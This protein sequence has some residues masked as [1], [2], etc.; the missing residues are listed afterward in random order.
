[1]ARMQRAGII[2][3][4]IGCVIALADIRIAQGRLR[5]AMRSYGRGL[6]LAMAQGHPILRGIADMYVGMSQL[7]CEQN[8]L[9]S[10]TEHLL[11]SQELGEHMG[12]PQNPYRWRVAMARITQAQGDLDGALELLEEAQRRYVGDFFPNVRPVAALVT[13]LWL[14]QGRLVEALDWAHE[15]GLSAHDELSYLHE[16]EHITLARILLAHAQTDRSGHALGEAT[17]LLAR[18][19]A[20]AEAGER[21]GNVIEILILQA[22]AHQVQSDIP[23]ALAPL[24]RALTLAEREG[25]VR[26]F[27]DEGPLMGHLLQETLARG[28]LPGYVEKLL[29]AFP[30][31]EGRGLR[32]ESLAPT[33]SV[34]SPQ[35]SALVEPLSARELEVLRLFNTELSG[36]EIAQELVIGLSTVRTYT[37]SIYT[38]LKVNSRRAA[39]KRAA[40]LGLI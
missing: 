37:K 35:S 31:A 23:A 32:T 27:V 16:F 26:L 10:A 38:K 21:M 7:L 13:R 17:R 15:Q 4:A 28:I 18:L 19:L 14:A 34:L 39:V 9:P 5:E 24:A 29:A 36:P 1:M 3:Q 8:E 33:R 30:R 40:E 2:A 25:Y 20:A 6:Q 11:R 22:L 12:L